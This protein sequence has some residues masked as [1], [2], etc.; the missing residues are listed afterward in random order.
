MNLDQNLLRT[1]A[2]NSNSLVA[3]RDWVNNDS[4]FQQH[5]KQ[6]I[7]AK[8]FYADPNENKRIYHY[9]KMDRLDSILKAKRFYIGSIKD[10]NDP[11]EISYT[12]NLAKKV[13]K[14]LGATTSEID[15]F[16]Q[17]RKVTFFDTY[18][19]CFSYSDYNQALQNYGDIA[20]GF[21]TQQ[22][23][24][25][26][27]NQYTKPKFENMQIGDGYVFPLKVEYDLDVQKEYITSIMVEWLRAYRGLRYTETLPIANAIRLQCLKALFLLSLCF[28]RYK[29]HQEEIRF[30]I[31]KITQD[32]K[33]QNDTV[34]N[35]YPKS[36]AYI[37]QN[38][39]KEIVVTH[40]DDADKNIDALK[41]ILNRN[42]F[43][44]VKVRLT[45]LDY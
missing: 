6:Y 28:K 41:Q 27:A 22:I 26:L 43:A 18:I 31:E 11:M 39:L 45:D 16:N 9:T 37:K 15:V 34:F 17:D 44:K 14:S 19:W 4:D 40:K 38:M 13:L 33:L 8:R 25:S 29:Y 24:E 2:K 21:D 7:I 32:S 42:D 20:L 1:L 23:Q 3:L 35:G 36:V 30:V 5:S 12:Y 10:M